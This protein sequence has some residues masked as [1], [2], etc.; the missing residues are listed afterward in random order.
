MGNLCRHKPAPPLHAVAV[1]LHVCS[2]LMQHSDTAVQDSACWAVA[3]ISEGPDERILAC[4]NAGL[5][6][7]VLQLLRTQRPTVMLPA[8]RTFG[9]YAV[10]SNDTA[11][12]IL[13]MGVLQQMAPLMQ[14][15]VEPL[16]RKE[17]C[18][19]LSNVAAGTSAQVQSVLDSDLMPFAI[20]CMSDS[21]VEV[22]KE[23]VW[24]V[25]NI[26]AAGTPDQRRAVIEH[27][28]CIPPL[29]T[30][31]RTRD[32]EIRRAALEAIEAVLD[33]GESLCTRGVN[34]YAACFEE[35]GIVDILLDFQ[36]SPDDRVR[37][38]TASVM[39]HWH[40]VN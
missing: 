12:S 31:L 2:A 30:A 6:P 37:H 24:V 4:Q 20:R 29:C 32:V 19:L 39:S 34:P 18:F 10:I 14:P 27:F 15:H 5:I 22:Q 3:Y 38:R 7:I 26:G 40:S 8:I 25:A 1:A 23:A 11:Q 17:C 16:M 35:Q 9:N 33:L 36:D 13:E 21:D 28:N